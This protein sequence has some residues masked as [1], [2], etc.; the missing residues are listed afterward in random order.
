MSFS[1]FS[2]NRVI[3]PVSEAVVP[4]DNL[5][6]A[7]GFGV[8]ETLKVRA[9]IVYFARQHVQRL[10]HSAAL[11]RLEHTQSEDSIL[12]AITELVT[13]LEIKS[14]NIKVMLIGARSPN[15]ALLFVFATAPL[16]PDRKF[17]RDGVKTITSVYERWLPNAKSLNMLP[18]YLYYRDAQ[19]AGCYDTLL[20]DNN[21]CIREGTRTNFFTLRGTTVYSPPADQI[22]EGVTRKTVISVLKKNG[23]RYAEQAIKLSEIESY[24][25]AFLTSTSTKILPIRAINGTTLP[26]SETIYRIIRDYDRFLV[27][28]KGVY[29]E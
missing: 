11:I 15:D 27:E 7:Y 4:I 18:S 2:R 29:P 12:A 21:G 25:G 16:Y 23:F 17:Y 20:V 5:E 28:C 1:H 26:L 24:D 10:L 22:L 8:Y 19:R 14:C 9:G 3:L 13:Y 6:Y